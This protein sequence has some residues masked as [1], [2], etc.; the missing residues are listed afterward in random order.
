MKKKKAEF[1]II[2]TKNGEPFVVPDFDESAWNAKVKQWNE[3]LKQMEAL[4]RENRERA[5]K[6][7][8]KYGVIIP[9]SKPVWEEILQRIDTGKEMTSNDFQRE[10]PAI[11]AFLESKG[12]IL[13]NGAEEFV[14]WFIFIKYRKHPFGE[15]IANWP[16]VELSDFKEFHRYKEHLFEY[17]GTV[18]DYPLSWQEI[19]GGKKNEHTPAKLPT[20]TESKKKAP[21]F[22]QLFVSGESE[23]VLVAAENVGIINIEGQTITWNY[24]GKKGAIL[25]LWDAVKAKGLANPDYVTTRVA[26]PVIAQKFGTSV[27]PNI[28]DSMARYIKPLKED[29][30][31]HL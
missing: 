26:C 25:A 17:G 30:M 4:A 8:Q 21:I 31:L 3:M 23:R 24:G 27:D 6:E 15:M 22:E 13:P 7:W 28:Y 18:G 5:V 11:R 12:M 14:V 2:F 10:F 1:E 20:N 29:I 9:D 16:K 19:E